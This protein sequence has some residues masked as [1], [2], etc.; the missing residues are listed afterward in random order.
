MQPQRR[1]LRRIDTGPFVR[2]LGGAPEFAG[3]RLSQ[4]P[5]V[6]LRRVL[7]IV[8]VRTPRQEWFIRVHPEAGY[9]LNVLVLEEKQI[10][11]PPLLHLVPPSLGEHLG[12]FAKRKRL[13]TAI[14]RQGGVFLWPLPL[15]PV[16][17]K[18]IARVRSAHQAARLAMRSWLRVKWSGGR[19][20]VEVA[21]D[22]LPGPEW[23][24]EDLGSI[25]GL[26]FGTRVIGSPD[27][28]VVRRIRGKR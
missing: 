9:T 8:E 23:P 27:D 12:G 19:W 17:R 15:P 13:C 11:A 26:A 22:D 7:T 24:E 16:G 6:P 28:A 3:L 18:P 1:V 5:V 10:K 20:E 21:T 14:N 4:R 2:P 25:L